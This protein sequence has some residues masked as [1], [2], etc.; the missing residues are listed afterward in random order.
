MH[1]PI[2]GI[3]SG[4]GGATVLFKDEFV[5]S[6]ITK[7]TSHTPDIDV[8]GEGW[9]GDTFPSGNDTDWRCKGSSVGEAYF[10]DGLLLTDICNVNVAVAD[11]TVTWI[12]GDTVGSPPDCHLMF[13]TKQGSDASPD[14]WRYEIN[15]GKLQERTGGSTATRHTYASYQNGAA[16]DTYIIITDDDNV[17]V[18]HLEDQTAAIIDYTSGGTREH[19]LETH[20]GWGL[21]YS[22]A[23][24]YE[25]MEITE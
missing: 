15:N 6:T 12:L 14:H 7:L 18:Y 19:K 25:S 21:T 11:V 20:F 22:E 5:E 2:T 13:N 4:G 10:D 9:Y 23:T 17:K 24:Q 16:G 1:L 3:I 8:E